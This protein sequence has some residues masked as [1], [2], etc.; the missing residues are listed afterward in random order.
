MRPPIVGAEGKA[1]I[2]E[3]KVEQAAKI[4]EGEASLSESEASYECDE[5]GSIEIGAMAMIQDDVW[6]RKE[7]EVLAWVEERVDEGFLEG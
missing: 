5:R 1:D 7:S 3:R 2:R 4:K 6:L